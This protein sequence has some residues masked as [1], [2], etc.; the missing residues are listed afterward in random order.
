MPFKSQD[1]LISM[2]SKNP[3]LAKTKIDK[4]KRI[5]RPIVDSDNPG[6]SDQDKTP[7]KVAIAKRLAKGKMPRKINRQKDD[8][9]AG[10][11]RNRMNRQQT[12]SREG[13]I[14]TPMLEDEIVTKR[15][16]VGY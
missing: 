6:Y 14:I 11:V 12:G 16:K 10:A 1:E 4:A 5:G 2:V 9:L 8:R 3:M 15:K 7:R 13:K